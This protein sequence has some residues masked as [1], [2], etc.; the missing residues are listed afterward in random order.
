MKN[1]YKIDNYLKFWS[2]LNHSMVQGI[3]MTKHTF[4]CEKDIIIHIFYQKAS[5]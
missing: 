1:L 2:V 4:L 5:H 3:N